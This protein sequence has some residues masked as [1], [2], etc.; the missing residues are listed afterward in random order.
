MS[1]RIKKMRISM[2]NISLIYKHTY[3]LKQLIFIGAIKYDVINTVNVYLE[4]IQ[5]I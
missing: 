5:N 2:A 3:Q 4:K 1:I